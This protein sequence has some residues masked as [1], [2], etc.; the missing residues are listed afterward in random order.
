VVAEIVPQDDELV[1]DAMVTVQDIDRVA[2][3][4]E[5]TIR[6]STLN[7]KRTP[8]ISGHV[9]NISADATTDQR[10][11]AAYYTA[12]ISV[13]EESLAEMEDI[14]LVAGMPAEVY[15]ETGSRT[16]MQYVTK[17]ITDSW[18]RSFRED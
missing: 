6:M 12:R 2:A 4:Q 10:T 1:I 7:A 15:I 16:F 9:L 18:A 11:G 13:N 17:S 8:S 3:G 14:A 5:A